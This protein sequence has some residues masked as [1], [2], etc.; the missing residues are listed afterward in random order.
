VAG[1]S[2]RRSH[3]PPSSATVLRPRPAQLPTEWREI[4][5]ENYERHVR[6]AL[7]EGSF[8]LDKKRAPTLAEYEEPF[9]EASR[10]KGNKPRSLHA[11][12]T[13]LRRLVK[14]LGAM[15]LDAPDMR[16]RVGEYQTRMLAD[17]Y[18]AKTVKNDMAALEALLSLAAD[19]GVIASVPRLPKMHP[20]KP[21]AELLTAE[22]ASRVIAA[23]PA[24]WQRTWVLLL[25]RTGIRLGEGLALKWSDVDLTTGSL[26]IRA[27]RWRGLEG[28]PK[29]GRERTVPLCDDARAALAAHRHLLGRYVFCQEDGS[30]FTDWDVREVVPKACK[31]AGI[32]RRVTN[33]GLRH[34]VGT[35][36]GEHVNA[37]KVQAFLGHADLSTTR[38]YVRDTADGLREAARVLELASPQVTAT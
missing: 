22:E 5:F 2:A 16:A 4:A 7:V 32:G 25:L 11:K 31:A 23:T 26:R 15:L 21:R 36:L 9:M 12:E 34:T 28:T 19:R 14:E 30:P 18:S 27:T 8:G 29:G 33:H 24:G 10:A 38:Q 13:I 6:R 37:F 17:G 3:D 1:C 20:P 35:V